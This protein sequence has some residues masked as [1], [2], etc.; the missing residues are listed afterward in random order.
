MKQLNEVQQL[1]I[2][3]VISQF[4]TGI[5]MEYTDEGI[6]ELSK[7]EA[8]MSASLLG[9]QNEKEGIQMRIN[10]NIINYNLKKLQK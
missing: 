10:Q 6:E 2:T 7:I 1:L 8:N 3:T 9:V 5:E 4:L